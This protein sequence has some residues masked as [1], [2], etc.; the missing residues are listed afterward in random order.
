METVRNISILIGSILLILL[1]LMIITLITPF[2]LI[3]KVWVSVKHENRKARDIV[4]GF[5]TYFIAIASSIDKFGNCAFGGFLN[6][7]LLKSSKYKFGQN[8]ETVS[9]VLGWAYRY[10]DLNETGLMLRAVVNWI[11]FT[12]KDHCEAARLIGLERA[13]TKLSLE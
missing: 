13:K 8:H 2:A 1:S 4:S 11:D 9:E 12:V 10:N 7:S 5:V 6:A 3:W